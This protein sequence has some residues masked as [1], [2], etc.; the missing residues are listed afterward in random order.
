MCLAYIELLAKMDN[1]DSLP[2]YGHSN[3]TSLD[4]GPCHRRIKEHWRLTCFSPP[5]W[6]V[7]ARLPLDIDLIVCLV[8]SGFTTVTTSLLRNP[9]VFE[10]DRTIQNYFQ[11]GTARVVCGDAPVTDSVC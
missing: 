3:S 9:A 5:T 1:Q 4:E 7:V 8:E 2:I 10:V 11:S 6:Y